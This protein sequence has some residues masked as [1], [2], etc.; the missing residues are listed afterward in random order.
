MNS[1]RLA[2]AILGLSLCACG[3]EDD[4]PFYGGYAGKGEAGTPVQIAGATATPIDIESLQARLTF[5]LASRSARAEATLIFTTGETD[6]LP[7]FDLRQTVDSASLDG[8][9]LPAGSIHSIAVPGSEMMVVERVLP[10]GS[11]HTLQ[12]SYEL[13]L[14]RAAG[15]API[16]EGYGPTMVGSSIAGTHWRWEDNER[17]FFDLW[18][19][20]LYGRYLEVWLPANL[21]HDEYELS[22]DLSIQNTNVLHRPIT[23]AQVSGA[24]N[25]YHLAFPNVTALSPMFVI[26]AEDRLDVATASSAV[27]IAIEAYKLKTNPA[28]LQNATTR[29]AQALQQYSAD[30]GP[31][32]HGDRFTTFLSYDR[33][34]E[35]AGATTSHMRDLEH[36]VFHSWWGRGLRPLTAN[37]GWIDEAFVVYYLTPKQQLLQAGGPPTVLS[38]SEPYSRLTPRAAYTTGAQLMATVAELVGGR[39][40]FLPLMRQLY[41]ERAPGAMSTA[42][43]EQFFADITGEPDTIAELFRLHVYG[44]TPGA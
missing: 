12:L 32:V 16:G 14:P 35:Y 4:A 26:A 6:G 36:E 42:E 22:M 23:N 18:L 43:L 5:D 11:H 19:S 29:V 2:A 13:G 33:S 8:E 39:E 7:M 21:I 15:V 28:D 10:A 37:D 27:G 1:Y 31:Y 25:E 40:A 17:M 44:N 24:A 3:S 30:L 34:M 9:T 20:D 41:T 38:P